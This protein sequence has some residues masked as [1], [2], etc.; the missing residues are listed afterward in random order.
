MLPQPLWVATFCPWK[1]SFCSYLLC[2]DWSAEL[3]PDSLSTTLCP[4][5]LNARGLGCQLGRQ[6]LN[7]WALGEL[8][9]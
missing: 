4:A 2:P 9:A 7:F 8:T 1:N 3:L 5:E 6:G